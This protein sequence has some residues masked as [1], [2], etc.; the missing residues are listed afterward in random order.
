M[1]A[2]EARWHLYSAT[3]G[4]TGVAIDGRRHQCRQVPTKWHLSSSHKYLTV[5]YDID[6]VVHDCG[7]S[8]ALAME[9]P[10]PCAKLLI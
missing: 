8:S 6:G 7:D 4:G 1:Y 10:Q 2:H 5:A 9:L 3:R